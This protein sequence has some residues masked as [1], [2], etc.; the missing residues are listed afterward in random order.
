MKN[1]QIAK[2]LV[3]LRTEKGLTQEEVATSLSISNKTLS[4]WENGTSAPDLEKL[5]ALAI[6]FNVTTDALLGRE[7]LDSFDVQESLRGHY[8]KANNTM[9]VAR[10][11]FETVEAI[12]PLTCDAFGDKTQHDLP[13]YESARP[14]CN[15]INSSNYYHYFKKSD[16]NNLS[17]ML[18]RNNDNF[19]WLKDPDQQEKISELLSFLSE[20]DVMEICY[21]LHSSACSHS[22]TVDFIAKKTGLPEERVAE[23]MTQLQKWNR[24]SRI[25]A[26]MNEGEVLLYEYHGDG[27]VLSLLSIAYEK[28][29]FEKRTEY[30]YNSVGQV[31]MIRRI[32]K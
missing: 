18:L 10:T 6:F 8:A 11:A 19:S 13:L 15:V 31:K 22:V 12:F 1:C 20:P 27:L 32:P 14:I 4:K 17:V 24:C 30:N 28:V 29:N 16:R 9:D 5:I 23:I 26:H 2:I 3:K 25:R 21:F 7:A